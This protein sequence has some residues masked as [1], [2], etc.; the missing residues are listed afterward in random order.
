MST[1]VEAEPTSARLMVEAVSLLADRQSE[2]D[3]W[4]KAQFDH[5]REVAARA[6]ERCAQL[7]RRLERIEARLGLIVAPRLAPHRTNG[8]LPVSSNGVAST[9]ISPSVASSPIVS[10]PT[11]VTAARPEL[12][13][14]VEH[15]EAVTP[16][17]ANASRR[18]P[19]FWELLGDT[20]G[21]RVGHGLMGAGAVGIV[22][23]LL[24]QFGAAR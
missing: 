10:A 15:D 12:A 24:M 14:P 7:E 23:A 2:T 1:L 6:E 22:Y 21:Q 13:D 18:Q 3:A 4:L 17:V 8:R 19:T 9:V 5:A 11:E 16:E 20:P